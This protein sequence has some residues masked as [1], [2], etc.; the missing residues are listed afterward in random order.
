MVTSHILDLWQKS[1]C[2]DSYSGLSSF[3]LSEP[4]FLLSMVQNNFLS[5]EFIFFLPHTLSLM[6]HGG[7]I[8]YQSWNSKTEWKRSQLWA[9]EKASSWVI[10]MSLLEQYTELCISSKIL[11]RY[12]HESFRKT[13]FYWLCVREKESKE[14]CRDNVRQLRANGRVLRIWLV[15]CKEKR[16]LLRMEWTALMCSDWSDWFYYILAFTFKIKY[17]KSI[18]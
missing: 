8:L 5:W 17:I 18:F 3:H 13:K 10:I 2:H 14:V 11:H 9:N 1:S 6:S 7:K 15:S 12:I 4:S 16:L